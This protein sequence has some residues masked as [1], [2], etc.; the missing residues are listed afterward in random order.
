MVTSRAKHK[1]RHWLN[2]QQT[3]QAT[4]FALVLERELKRYRRTLKKVTEGPSWRRTSRARGCHASRTSARLGFA[5]TT[6][7]QAGCPGC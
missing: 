4:D 6:V 5:K 2:I 3:A 1:I 7:A